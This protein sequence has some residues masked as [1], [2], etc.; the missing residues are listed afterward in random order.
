MGFF[1]PR[2]ERLVFGKKGVAGDLSREIERKQLRGLQIE[3]VGIKLLAGPEDFHRLVDARLAEKDR[4][5]IPESPDRAVDVAE[6]RKPHPKVEM[7][8]GVSGCAVHR[9]AGVLLCP[10]RMPI[11]IAP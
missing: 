5:Q 7:S 8:G 6:G 2:T 3:P 4:P 1:Q 11:V 9:L 10:P